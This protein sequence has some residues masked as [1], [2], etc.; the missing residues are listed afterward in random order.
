MRGSGALFFLRQTLRGFL[1]LALG[2]ACLWVVITTAMIFVPYV[3][4]KSIPERSWMSFAIWFSGL[5]YW[6]RLQLLYVVPMLFWSLRKRNAGL[7]V[8]ALANAL[9]VAYFVSMFSSEYS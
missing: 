1:I 6:P 7:V 8:G 2:H 5:D 4:A 9:C 3:V